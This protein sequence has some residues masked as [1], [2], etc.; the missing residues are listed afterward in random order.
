MVLTRLSHFGEVCPLSDHS[1]S[2]PAALPN[3]SHHASNSKRFPVNV[4]AK[5]SPSSASS[6]TSPSFSQS[7]STVASPLLSVTI[8]QALSPSS[9]STSTTVSSTDLQN[10]EVIR[11]HIL[12]LPN[13]IFEKIFSYLSFKNIGEIRRT[14]KRFEQIGSTLLN[15]SFQ[16]LQNQM[17]QRF[18]SI[19]G[20]MPRRES[21]RRKHPLARESD[22]V[23]TL[24]MRLTLLQMS[25]GKHIERKHCCF[26]AGDILDEVYRILTYIKK[27]PNLGRAYKVT[28][29]LFDLSTMAMEYFK[30]HIEP[31][32]PEITYFGSDFLD[33]TT[34][35]SEGCSVRSPSGSGRVSE[36]EDELPERDPLPP[37]N[38]VLRKRIRRIRQG[39][40]RYNTQLVALK[41]ELKGCK[42]KIA[43]QHKQMME[44]ATR[45]DEYDKKFEES[46]RKFST[47]LQ[48]L[49]KCKT[50][51]QYWRSKSPA[52]PLL[53]Y[54]C[55]QSVGE[56][57]GQ[58]LQAGVLMQGSDEAVVYVPLA[59]APVP[60]SAEKDSPPG[61]ILARDEGRDRWHAVGG[62]VR[63]LERVFDLDIHNH[64]R[65][66][67]ASHKSQ[68]PASQPQAL[69]SG[70]SSSQATVASQSKDES[71]RE[72]AST[73][74]TSHSN[75]SHRV[76]ISQHSLGSHPQLSTSQPV[77][78]S[79]LL[80]APCAQTASDA[81]SPSTTVT[82]SQPV[83]ASQPYSAFHACA[84]SQD[85]EHRWDDGQECAE[86][87]SMSRSCKR[88][89]DDDMDSGGLKRCSSDEDSDNCDVCDDTVGRRVKE[90]KRIKLDTL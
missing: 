80:S 24:H 1:Y 48:E 30:E 5:S 41:R 31:R 49:N 3:P 39:M 70:L 25:F 10:H 75:V 35:F 73:L 79:C 26:F 19:K 40:R 66:T 74:A 56:G 18:Q 6:L 57:S 2:D 85:S 87:L 45:M 89:L 43:D 14:C 12:H 50:E 7:A 69:L 32:L 63:N 11:M 88:Y 28:D 55:G 22:I 20:Q 47:V 36:P 15:A 86:D 72:T 44:Y 59:A 27:T 58:Q 34:P 8:S 53:C 76:Y 60:E 23:E 42:G 33:I 52:H 16:R 82:Q 21:A 90:R 38:M 4:G 9:L 84:A 64:T 65:P 51:L 61:V 68:T 13:E 29:E 83:I 71:Q 62:S 81:L 78:D 67:V 17:L 37:S 46:S 54:S 77:A